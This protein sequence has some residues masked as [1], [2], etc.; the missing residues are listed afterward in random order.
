MNHAYIAQTLSALADAQYNAFNARIVATALPTLGVRVPDLRALA[1]EIERSGWADEFLDTQTPTT[2]DELTLRGFVVAGRRVPLDQMLRR[3]DGFV[4][5]IENWAVCDTFCG[6][7]KR[8]AKERDAWWPVIER[9]ARSEREFEVRF[10]VVLSMSYFLTD[11]W[12]D[13]AL[14]LWE[15]IDPR[16]V[17]Y[18]EMAL[19]WGLAT[20]AAKQ[21]EKTIEAIETG[22]YSPA[23]VRRAVR[24]C[25]ESLRIDPEDKTYLK[26]LIR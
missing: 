9:Y 4:P 12:I 7:L 2:H 15:S 1:K 26:T 11:E 3:V 8:V 21:R 6:S 13:L 20:A 23:V 5:Q 16:G 19:G 25:C 24:K 17:Y 22:R 18:I 14:Q 10:A